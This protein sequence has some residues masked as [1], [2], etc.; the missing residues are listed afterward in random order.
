MQPVKTSL[1]QA[2]LS[3]IPSPTTIVN[4]EHKINCSNVSQFTPRR[5][6]RS[7][8]HVSRT[9]DTGVDTAK[10]VPWLAEGRL[11]NPRPLGQESAEAIPNVFPSWQMLTNLGNRTVS[12]LLDLCQVFVIMPPEAIEAIHT[13]HQ[14]GP[15]TRFPCA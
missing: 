3:T 15:W 8:D 11:A 10:P 13:H 6:F 2:Y 1:L 7:S 5:I 9:E 12:L 4:A 14:D